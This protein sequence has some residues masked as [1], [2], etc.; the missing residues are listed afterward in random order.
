M[1]PG[2]WPVGGEAYLGVWRRDNMEYTVSTGNQKFALSIR[3][4]GGG[5]EVALDGQRLAVDMIRIGTTRC[6]SLLVN[7]R[8]Y[9]VQ[10]CRNGESY[11]VVL[12]QRRYGVTVESERARL[13]KSLTSA[14]KKPQEAEEVKAAMPGLVVKVEVKEGDQVRAGD[15]LVIVEAMK[16]E[17]ELRA[18]QPGVI[19]RVFVHRGMTVDQGQT[20]VLIQ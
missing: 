6:Y 5:L 16:M 17:N 2:K 9:E 4:A 18:P 13:L 12:N 14:R 20:L 8:S 10:V 1:T 7:G 3:E 11:G 19:K 15:G